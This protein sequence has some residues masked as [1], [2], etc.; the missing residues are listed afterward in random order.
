MSGVVNTGSIV[1]VVNAQVI[2]LRLIR[3]KF[4]SDVGRLTRCRI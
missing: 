3:F 2:L 1:A 4:L